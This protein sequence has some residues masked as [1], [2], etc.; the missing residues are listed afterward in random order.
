MMDK[1]ERKARNSKVE[2]MLM[3]WGRTLLHR[4]AGGDGYPAPEVES[5]R[6]SGVSGLS[7][8]GQNYLAIEERLVQ[9]KSK[10][11]ARD[12]KV[13]GPRERIRRR[14]EAEYKAR[15]MG[16]SWTLMGWIEDCCQL[17]RGQRPWGRKSEGEY[18][19]WRRKMA[20]ELV[21]AEDLN[22]A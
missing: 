5:G 7:A 8:I 1:L 12:A 21:E 18:R 2:R 13:E 17:D 4:E 9:L 16:R 14:L 22:L 20:L 19:L 6:G 3:D 10:A 11:S 15:A